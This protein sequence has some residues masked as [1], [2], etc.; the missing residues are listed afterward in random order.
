[1]ALDHPAESPSGFT[2]RL[3]T[4]PPITDSFGHAWRLTQNNHVTINGIRDFSI[5]GVNQ[6]VYAPPMLCAFMMYGGGWMYKVRPN[7]NWEDLPGGPPSA[8]TTANAL[9]DLGKRIDVLALAVTQLVANDHV[10]SDGINA[11]H[12]AILR[13][14][15]HLTRDL[16]PASVRFVVP[17]FI[18]ETGEHVPMA[19]NIVDN[20]TSV[21]PIEFDN[22]AGTAVAEPAGDNATI[23]IDSAAFTVTLQASPL[24][25][26][27]TPVQP[28]QDGAVG[29]ITYTD[30]LA[31]GKVLTATLSGIT[32]AADTSAASVHFRD[33]QITTIPI[34]P[35]PPPAP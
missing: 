10:I 8:E 35:P 9:V 33:D 25:A 32:I 13:I 6:L 19:I 16:V 31:D 15:D 4:D 27:V 18:T 2:I 1:M 30:T 5:G 12:D 26:L 3:Y 21:I 24:A 28:P 22:S 14:L 23:S 17:Y 7:E 20:M 11:T 29:N 34:A